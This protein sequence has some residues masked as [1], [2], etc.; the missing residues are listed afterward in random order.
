[1]AVVLMA[2]PLG[3]V[4]QIDFSPNDN[5]QNDTIQNHAFQN[6]TSRVLDAHSFEPDEFEQDEFEQDDFQSQAEQGPLGPS[7]GGDALLAALLSS[8]GLSATA[9]MPPIE[10]PTTDPTITELA[11]ADPLSGGS[12]ADQVL[13]FGGYDVWSNGSSTYAGL[14]WAANGLDDDGFILRLSM[15]NALERFRTP[16][17]TYTTAIFR[18][19]LMPGWRFKRGEFELRLFAGPDFENHNF[20]PDKLGARW[21][22]PHAG[23]RIAA[24]TWAQPTPEMMLATAFYATTIAGGYGF[25]AAAGW[26]LIDAFWIGPELSGSRDDFSRQTRLGI[27]LTGLQSGAFEWSAAI[28]LVSDSFGRNGG[29]GRLATQLRP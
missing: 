19:A 22:G 5:S 25:R 17:R 27:H 18:A 13:M 4:A 12:R 14:H 1:M 29:Y 9:R 11:T 7:D 2:G 6:H 15:S 3:A 20:T 8:P 23:L 16:S 21:R 28:G 26:R 24:E 10:S